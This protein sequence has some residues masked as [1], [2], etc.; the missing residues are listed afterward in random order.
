M[1][2]NTYNHFSPYSL[3]FDDN[4]Y[5]HS[6]FNRN[7]ICNICNWDSLW[8]KPLHFCCFTSVCGAL[9]RVLIS[10]RSSCYFPTYLTLGGL[11]E[12]TYCALWTEEKWCK[13]TKEKSHEWRCVCVELENLLKDKMKMWTMAL[14][15]GE[16]QNL[17]RW[18]KPWNG[19]I[20]KL[21]PSLKL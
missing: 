19:T 14:S 18:T 21:F 9:L 15:P 4:N 8:T 3:Y 12:G 7:N 17:Q 1:R 13:L 2:G 6:Y 11:S 16:P 20:A 5:F 10:R